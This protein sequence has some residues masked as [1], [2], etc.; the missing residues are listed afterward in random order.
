MTDG[1]P[2]AGSIELTDGYPA[3]DTIRRVGQLAEPGR[4]LAGA[5]S[6]RGAPRGYA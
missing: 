4:T 5:R 1:A 3:E 6:C 2:V